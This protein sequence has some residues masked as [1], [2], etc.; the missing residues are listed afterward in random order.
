M[1][2]TVLEPVYNGSAKD[3]DIAL[4]FVYCAIGVAMDRQKQPDDPA[5]RRYAHLA[6][7]SLMLGCDLL[8]SKSITVIRCLV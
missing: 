5:A 2:T 1:V 7:I 4:F 3:E 6:R 8:C